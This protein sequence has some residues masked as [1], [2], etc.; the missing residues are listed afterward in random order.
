MR[1][2][3][4]PRLYRTPVGRSRRIAVMHAR[5]VR[6]YPGRKLA[7]MGAVFWNSFDKSVFKKAL[8]ASP[9][10]EFESRLTDPFVTPDETENRQVALLIPL[11]VPALGTDSEGRCRNPLSFRR[12]SQRP[13]SGRPPV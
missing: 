6:E 12:S 7:L 3:L 8:C 1:G 9:L 5:G 2:T 11:H 10:T 13:E 4:L